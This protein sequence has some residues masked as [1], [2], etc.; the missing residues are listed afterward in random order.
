MPRFKTPIIAAASALLAASAV[1]LAGDRGGDPPDNATA[2]VFTTAAS[3]APAVVLSGVGG[4]VDSAELRAAFKEHQSCLARHGVNVTPVEGPDGNGDAAAVVA[5]AV[6]PDEIKKLQDADRECAPA[7]E[8]ALQKAMPGGHLVGPVQLSA[9][10]NGNVEPIDG[11]TALLGPGHTAAAPTAKA[12]PS[13][14]AE[15]P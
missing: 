11:C 9:P 14:A 10:R 3:A 15:T 6:D 7:L 5:R 13:A 8:K 12:A 2:G 4:P 1:A